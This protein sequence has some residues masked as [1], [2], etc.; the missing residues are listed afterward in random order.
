MLLL[1]K[2]DI[3]NIF[4]LRKQNS[5]IDTFIQ[6]INDHDLQEGTKTVRIKDDNQMM[7]ILNDESIDWLITLQ[8]H[9]P[10]RPFETGF[11]LCFNQVISCIVEDTIFVISLIF[12]NISSI[13]NS[14]ELSLI[15]HWYSM[16]SFMINEVKNMMVP[17]YLNMENAS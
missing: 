9:S 12:T 17:I 11:D 3:I 16:T 15:Y 2:T 7:S 6:S 13:Q 5:S 10:W 14:L 1:Q 8:K 4:C